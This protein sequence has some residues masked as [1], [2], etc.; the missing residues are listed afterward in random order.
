MNVS[1]APAK[2]GDD[3]AGCVLTGGPRGALEAILLGPRE[4]ESKCLLHPT[5]PEVLG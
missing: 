1:E 3:A 5:L 4:G 2:T